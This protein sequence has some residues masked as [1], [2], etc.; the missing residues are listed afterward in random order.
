MKGVTEASV[1]MTVEIM[2]AMGILTGMTMVCMHFIQI[3]LLS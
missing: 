3:S 1:D 2:A